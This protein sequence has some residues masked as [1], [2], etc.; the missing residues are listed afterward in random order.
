MI[1]NYRKEG[2]FYTKL[3]IEFKLSK[4]VGKIGYAVL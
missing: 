1:K 4:R 3:N 2:V